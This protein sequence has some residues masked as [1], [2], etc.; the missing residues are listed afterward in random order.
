MTNHD[1]ARPPKSSINQLPTPD[2]IFRTL[3]WLLVGLLY[4]ATVVF[5]GIGIIGFSLSAKSAQDFW[6]IPYSRVLV[7]SPF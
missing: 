2:R 3:G 1:L 7:V 5:L 4:V 6:M